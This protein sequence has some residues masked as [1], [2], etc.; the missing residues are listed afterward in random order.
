MINKFFSIFVVLMFAASTASA[1]STVTL[2]SSDE[3]VTL[4]DGQTLT[5]TGGA[6]TRVIIAD[7][8]SITLNGVTITGGIVCK[9][10]ATITLVGTNSVSGATY[11]A[12]IQI[13]GSGTTLTIRGEGSLSATGGDQSAG[14]GLNRAWDVDAMG[15]DI[16]I[17]GGNITATGDSYGAGIG[18][19][20]CFGDNSDKTA[21]LGNITIKGGTVR[22]IGGTEN[23]NG[24]GKGHAYLYGHAVVGTITI[25]DGIDLVDASSISESVTYMHV[26]N[27]TETN[28]T[29]NKS[30]YFTII[31]NGDRRIIAPKDETD[32][33]ITIADNI[34]NGT[35]TAVPTAKYLETVT[36]TATPAF[37]YRFVR[38]V[39]KD[40]D[41]NDVASTYNT[42]QMPKGGA[43]VSAEFA[44]LVSHGTTE[45]EWRYTTGQGPEDQVIETI[46]DGVTT[47]SIQTG[48]S[49][50]IRKYGSQ[51]RL[52]GDGT[53]YA[54]IPYAGGMGEFYEDRNP[55]YFSI[56]NNGET[57]YYDITL[58]DVGNGR[59]SVSILK[60]VP[61]MDAIPAQEYTGNAITPEPTVIAGSLSLTKGT[62][63]EYSYTN[64]TNCGTATVRVTFKGDYASLGSV[65]PKTFQ[66]VPKVT[67][68]GAL[69]LTQ[70]QNGT[71]AEIDGKY[72]DA[73]AFS[74]D[75]DIA[76]N[77][78]SFSR[79]FTANQ[80]STII[81]PFDVPNAAN[82]GSFYSFDGVKHEGDVWIAQVT[83]VTEV[84]ANTPYLFKP[85][86]SNPDLTKDVK[87]LVATTSIIPENDK[88]DFV[89]MY[90]YKEWAADADKDYGFAGEEDGDIQ[91]GEFVKVGAGASINPFRCYL[92]YKGTNNDLSKSA[93]ELPDRIIVRVTDPDATDDDSNTEIITPVSEITAEDGIK[94]WSYN[95][96]AYISAQP[97][98]EYR[99]VDM[100]GRTI[101]HGVTASNREEVSLNGINGIVIVKIGNQ[102]FKIKY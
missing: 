17:E 84:K 89:G 77:S 87:K 26:D 11:K 36:V 25:Y 45:F 70:D 55:T 58:T 35:L 39:V 66:I 53:F 75:Q 28:V 19:G 65:E 56:P 49:Y 60:T 24:I 21:T 59:W 102:T 88:W 13:G 54:N 23:G 33:T 47:V 3:A 6:K 69:T 61:Q 31:E 5:G 92:T 51:F 48:R 67:T 1:Q 82:C 40:S 98:M 16:V 78:V 50:S 86:T 9:G 76:V 79:T 29:A 99:I 71:Y 32:Y 62:D 12:G 100:G 80:Y 91:I 52:D 64:N 81:L 20:V 15:G 94:V 37:G 93:V 2:S 38:L 8:A 96:T 57:G 7:D 27:E 41:D 83:Q 68:L 85:S 34:E 10:T 18:T 4:T 42:F 43:I 63:Y 14:I 95:H 72:T 73:D 22:A 101:R 30:D 74:I 90:Q 46:Y 44:P 97:G